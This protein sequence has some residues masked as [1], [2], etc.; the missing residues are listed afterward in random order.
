MQELASAANLENLELND[1]L[2]F[3]VIARINGFKSVD[4][5]LAILAQDFNLEEV[6]R[7]ASAC[8]STRIFFSTWAIKPLNICALWIDV[9]ATKI[10]FG[11]LG[12]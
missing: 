9:G 6:N 11:D 12:N 4:K 10:F 5:T 1:Y 8:E 7:V 3:R 2:C